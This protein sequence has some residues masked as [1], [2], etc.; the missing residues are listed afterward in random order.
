M[1]NKILGLLLAAGEGSRVRGVLEADEPV[2]PLIKLGGTRIIDRSIASVVDIADEVAVL[3][4]PSAKYK[5]LDD[6]VRQYEGVKVL[7]QKS[8]HRKL[9]SLL[10]LP[11]VLLTQYHF[12]GDRRYLQG[13]DSIL[14]LPCDLVFENV[15]LSALVD[16]HNSKL[17][18][19]NRK[20]I[21]LLS[22]R[23]SEGGNTQLFK[24]DDGRVIA[25]KKFEGREV[26]G[27]E[28]STQA[29]VYVFSR[30]FLRNPLRA[31]LGFRAVSVYNHLTSGTW[32]DYGN[33]AN[34]VA[35]RLQE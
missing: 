24:M 7:K 26:E 17:Q 22:K 35:S 1:G 25:M 15:D 19:S 34:V 2:K 27:Y 11:Y 28:A 6:I 9:P 10:E 8:K 18:N 30:G 23:E 16:F 14:T 31:L 33:P 3:S 20:Q 29:G 13:F 32:T 21:T 5:P 4:F 12:S